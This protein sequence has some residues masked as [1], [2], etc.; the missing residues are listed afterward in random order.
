MA[1]KGKNQ[2]DFNIKTNGKEVENSVNSIGRALRKARAQ[3]NGMSESHEEYNSKVKEVAK[4]DSAYKG[5]K[6]AQQEQIDLAKDA[7]S[8][9]EKQSK[10][11]SLA[12]KMN[13]KEAKNTLSSV[14]E[15]LKELR[16]YTKDQEEGT[17]EWYKSI[18][19][20]AKAEKIH[21][22]M[23]KNQRELLN[24]TKKNID[25]QEDHN[26]ALNDFTQGFG[27]LF[28]SIKS[29]DLQ[30]AREGFN[31][32]A[33]GI[34]GATRAAMAFIATP[35][36]AA[37]AALTALFFAGREIFN[38]NQGLEVMN[39]EL[40]ALGVG[41]SE[42]GKVRDEINATAETF[43]KDFKDIATRA[44]SLSESFG[45]SMSEANDVIAQ[46][47]ADG[48]AQNSEFL[49]SLGEYDEFFAQA[50]YAAQDFADIINQGYELGIYTDKLPDALKE[51]DLSLREQTTSTRDALVNAFGATFTDDILNRIDK[52]ETT[53]KDALEEIAEEAE[54]SGLSM[55]QQAQLTADVFRGAGED[56]G[57]AL[58][59]LEAVGQAA[60]RE[61]SSVAKAELE[62]QEANEELNKAQSELFGIEDFGEIWIKIKTIA[63]N[64]ITGILNYYNFLID[65]YKLGAQEFLNLF[66]RAANGGMDVIAD[67]LKFSKP[68]LKALGVEVDAIVAGLENVKFKEFDFFSG[69]GKK[70]QPPEVD[71][72]V[73]AKQAEKAKERQKQREE[74]QKR[75]EERKKQ[76][77]EEE[78]KR[79]K[80]LDKLEADYVKKKEDREAKSNEAIA[81]LEKKRALDKAKEL[82]ASNELLDKIEA[83]HKIKVAEAKVEDEEE[84]LQE[85]R[86]FEARKQEIK[87]EIKLMQAE[88][89]EERELIKAEQENDKKMLKL[90]QDLADLKITEE[91]KNQLVELLTEKHQQ[92]LAEIEGKS[93]QKRQKEEEKHHQN[94][95]ALINNTLNAAINAVGAES[96][97]GQALVLAKQIQA[98]KEM[99]IQLGLFKSKM[100]LNVAEATGDTAKGAAKTASALPFPANIPLIIG[101]AAQVAGIISTI[102]KASSAGKS[103]KTRG[104]AKGG[105]TDAFGMGQ[106]DESGKEVAGVVHTNEY[107]VP[108]FVRQMPGVP[109]ILDY[110]ETKRKQSLGSYAQGGDVSSSDTETSTSSSNSSGDMF[111]LMS[112]LRTLLSRPLRAEI[113]FGYDAELRRQEL[114]KELTELEQSNQVKS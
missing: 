58:K 74:A 27:Q 48:G 88:T 9:Q 38:F 113:L 35:V 1:S 112:D 37:I 44:K 76:A 54:K 36:G 66:V 61:L 51:A 41:A 109:P 28:Q 82:E 57:G 108:E 43:N 17:D 11:F 100:A 104:F 63:V 101:F 22:D 19:E 75:E 70:Q 84:K 21:D 87:D 60:Q 110:L 91:E 56:A 85:L 102:K 30:G 2:F 55:Q 45:I 33:S 40:R 69:D 23:K 71:E 81:K 39:K 99:A 98:A 31:G 14:S 95:Q 68:A 29:G 49:D 52:G 59:V 46:G 106:R 10:L 103:V 64:A 50:G 20:L 72:A 47:L 8:A 96:K 13:G 16:K 3:L 114:Q 67:L 92:K 111:S 32:I 78:K 7:T 42:I 26:A 34:K 65:T 53:T 105:F 94:R 5:M 62:L 89:D 6:K 83:E 12:I 73:A 4:L 24:E 90:Q 80:E 77:A 97:L 86:D 18:K 79:L 93:L 15:N 107:V 25:A